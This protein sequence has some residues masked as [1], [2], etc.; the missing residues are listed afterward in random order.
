MGARLANPQPAASHGCGFRAWPNFPKPVLAENRAAL[1]VQ[2]SSKG[3]KQNV[4]AGQIPAP[5]R[6]AASG[7]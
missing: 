4:S 7:L 3:L 1:L 5:Q 2:A 6:G